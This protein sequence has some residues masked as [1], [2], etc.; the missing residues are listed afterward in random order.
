MKY[1][2]LFK[3]HIHSVFTLWGEEEDRIEVASCRKGRWW[4]K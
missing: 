4:A 2:S 3:C 1:S